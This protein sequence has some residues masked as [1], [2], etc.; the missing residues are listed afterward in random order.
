MKLAKQAKRIYQTGVC[1]FA[2]MCFPAF[3]ATKLTGIAVHN[4]FGSEQFIAALYKETVSADYKRLILDDDNKAMEIRVIADRLSARRFKQMWIEGMAINSGSRDLEKHAQNVADF[5]NF[6]KVRMKKGDILRIDRNKSNNMLVMINGVKLGE[7]SDPTFFDLLLRTWVG[8]VPLSS[9]F[10]EAM[11]VGGKIPQ[12]LRARLDSV[13]PSDERVALLKEAL[14]PSSDQQEKPAPVVAAAKPKP[15]PKPAVAATKVATAVAAA[16]PKPIVKTIPKPKPKPKPVAKPKP[17]PT[18][19]AAARPGLLKPES[20]F[21]DDDEDITF[22]AEDILS[23]Q[24]YI[25]KLNKWTRNF[26]SYP[27]YA[28]KRSQEGTVRIT[29]SLKRSGE[30]D[31]VTIKDSSRFEALD[32]AATDAIYAANPYPAVPPEIKG[33]QF[34]FSVPILFRLQ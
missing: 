16:K 28:L 1:C 19:V 27:K 8:P 18:Q 30:V 11:L 23:E 29:V 17:K 13:S 33:D 10:K 25:S 5:S 24:L 20:I 4:E 7:I 21:E 26:I 9:D 22:T 15:K 2:L 3:A 31:S 14:E 34:S 12:D 32:K 6:F